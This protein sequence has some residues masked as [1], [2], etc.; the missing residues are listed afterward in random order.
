MTKYEALMSDYPEKRATIGSV[1]YGLLSF[2][3]LP[4]CL[5]F[6]NIGFALNR[7]IDIW[8]E[9]L[10]HLANFGAAMILFREYLKDS[11][12]SVTL[13]PKKVLRKV[14]LVAA[15][16]LAISF[17][18][19]L[20]GAIFDEYYIGEVGLPLVE[21]DLF[22]FS[23]VLVMEKTVFG[24]ICVVLLAPITISCL[25]YATAFSTICADRPRL[26]YLVVSI[27]LLAP[28]AVSALLFMDPKQQLICYLARL[29]MHLLACRAYQR[30]DTV[31]T[32]IFILMA[33]NL[34]SCA[35][36]YLPLM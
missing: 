8:L 17:L 2:V 19:I 1:S 11:F 10:F 27:W 4:V 20:A 16:M 24:V 9:L 35:L 29:P 26:A 21:M 36:F 31:W 7:E 22:S 3:V 23:S 13:D 5:R 15:I 14:V 33:A 12:F 25:F 34:L 6:F 18:L 30:T 28:Y 32:P